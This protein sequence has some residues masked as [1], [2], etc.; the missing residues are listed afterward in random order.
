MRNPMTT[1][2]RWIFERDLYDNDC[3][4]LRPEVAARIDRPCVTQHVLFP[5]RAVVDTEVTR[6]DGLE[7]EYH[8]EGAGIC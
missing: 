8:P 7:R 2:R 4:L 3:T 1:N 6:V 5:D